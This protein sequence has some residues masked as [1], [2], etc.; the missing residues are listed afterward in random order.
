MKRLKVK[1]NMKVKRENELNKR[2]LSRLRNVKQL[3]GKL[4]KELK[5][6]LI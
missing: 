2:R 3:K 5:Q 4:Y 6:M 1:E